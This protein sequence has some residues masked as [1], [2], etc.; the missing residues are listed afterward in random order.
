MIEREQVLFGEGV[1]K[2]NDEER[3]ARRLLVHKL[4]HRRG[5]LRLATQ[6]IRDQLPDM[7]RSQRRE[8]DLRYLSAVVLDDCELAHQRMRRIDLIVPVGA[9][10]QQVLHVRL[11][12]QILEQVE[13]R[14][15]EPLQIVEEE[16]QRMLRPRE[17]ADKSPEHPLETPLRV[18]RREVGDRRM[19]ADD[20]AQ[21]GDEVDDEPSVRPQRLVQGVAPARQLGLALA[22]KRPHQ[23][24][25]SLDQRRIRDIALVLIR[26]CLTRTAR[27]AAP[28]PCAAR[29]PPQTCRCRNSP[30][31]APAPARRL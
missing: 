14:R 7:F 25:K 31:P 2:L 15:V 16:R 10:Q 17:H 8:R 24:L 18:F 6:R 4:R 22:E 9:D 28:A 19:I 29:A 27:A 11:G 13:C 21:F 20:Q 30:K 23:A 12:Q 1:K 3:V 26:T 5:A